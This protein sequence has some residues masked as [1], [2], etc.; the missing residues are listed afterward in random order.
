MDSDG[1]LVLK[2]GKVE[3][4]LFKD[5]MQHARIDGED[6][7]IDFVKHIWVGD[8]D[9]PPAGGD[10]DTSEDGSGQDDGQTES[11]ENGS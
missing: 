7:P 3:S 9:T 1:N 2:S 6:I 8:P 11:G 5:G 10:D 4:I